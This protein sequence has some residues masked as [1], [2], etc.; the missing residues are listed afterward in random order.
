MHLPKHE[1]PKPEELVKLE[2][3]KKP[4]KLHK[5]EDKPLRH[6]W[7]GHGHMGPRGHRPPV[8]EEE[9]TVKRK[10]APKPK[11]WRKF[12]PAPKVVIIPKPYWKPVPMTEKPTTM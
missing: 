2:E 7:M 4:L 3:E 1:L 5:M 12:H 9:F 10:Y 6:R 8:M 11:P